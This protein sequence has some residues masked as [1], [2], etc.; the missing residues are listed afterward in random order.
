MPLKIGIPKKNGFTEF[1]SSYKDPRTNKTHANGFSVDVFCAALTLLPLKVNPEFL[2]FENEDGES[3]GTYDDLLKNI[4]VKYDAVVGDVTI[5]ANRVSWADFALS[6]VD[7][8]VYILSYTAN[9]TAMLTIDQL[10]PY[11]N[12]EGNYSVGYQEGS[13]VKDFLIQQKNFSESRLRAYSTMTDYHKALSNGS[14]AAIY[15]E[16]P[17]IKLFLR[18]YGSDYTVDGPILRTNGFGFAFPLDSFLVP[19]ISRAITNVTDGGTMVEIEHKYF[20]KKQ[21]SEVEITRLPEKTP[22]LDYF[23]FIGLFI[24][25]G[26]ISLASLLCSEIWRSRRPVQNVPSAGEVNVNGNVPIIDNQV[27]QQPTTSNQCVEN[28]PS[29]GEVNITG[30]V[31][32]IENRVELQPTTSNQSVENVPSTGEVNVS[33]DVPIIDNQVEPNQRVQSM[34]STGEVNVSGDVPVIENQDQL[35][36]TTSN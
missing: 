33:R 18:K 3:L 4:S 20:G 6:Y 15:D 7:S 1:V 29:T 27:E 21:I 22:S 28:V 24:V 26:S 17:Y 31:P 5:M 14:V 23:N 32:I 9:L 11:F 34:P 8:S 12:K 10:R 35:H 25:T 19:L 30:D 13:F 36:L 16:L 2:P